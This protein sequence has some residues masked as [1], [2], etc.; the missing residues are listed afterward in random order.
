MKADT[1]TNVVDVYINYLRRKLATAY[2]TAH[3]QISESGESAAGNVVG[4]L[5][6][7]LIETVRGEGYRLAEPVASFPSIGDA[8]RKHVRSVRPEPLRGSIAAVGSGWRA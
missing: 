8:T 7:E 5:G 4:E 1:G 3:G 6:P 2:A